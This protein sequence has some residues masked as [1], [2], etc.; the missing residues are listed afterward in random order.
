MSA[1]SSSIRSNLCPSLPGKHNRPVSSLLGF[2][3]QAIEI[4]KGRRGAVNG[5]GSHVKDIDN[6][7]SNP[8]PCPSRSPAWILVMRVD[9]KI[10]C[11]YN[12]GHDKRSFI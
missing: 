6:G 4:S 10:K 1:S 9:R 3:G 2:L 5:P 8:N 12:Y 11:D 7:K